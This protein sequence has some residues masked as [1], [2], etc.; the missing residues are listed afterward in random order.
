M[1]ALNQ[2]FSRDML[3][4]MKFF[5]NNADPSDGQAYFM[6]FNYNPEKPGRF[7]TDNEQL[8]KLY[9]ARY[10]YNRDYVRPAGFEYDDYKEILALVENIN[11]GITSDGMA[12]LTYGCGSGKMEKYLKGK[13][14][15]DFCSSYLLMY[16]LLLHQ[17]YFLCS[18]PDKD[19]MKKYRSVYRIAEI[20]DK[21]KVQRLYE[22]TYKQFD[23]EQ[24]KEE[25]ENHI[26]AED[27]NVIRAMERES[28]RIG[29]MLT[30][31]AIFGVFSAGAGMMS[32]ACYMNGTS[33]KYLWLIIV[34][35]MIIFGIG[36]G[37]VT[38]M[39]DNIVKM[40]ISIKEDQKSHKFIYILLALFLILLI[41]VIKW[42]SFV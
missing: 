2:L 3:A 29:A 7:T 6:S 25:A 24:L 13:F 41:F 31:L 1:L 36:A 14:N 39:R 5:F 15:N 12:C 38:Y 27:T 30:V 42:R 18:S 28:T 10:G 8:N 22:R 11:F 32:V 17:R 40:F 33:R 16:A 21:L 9:A 37:T 4:R 19:G 26:P 20:S 23:I 34:L 35:S